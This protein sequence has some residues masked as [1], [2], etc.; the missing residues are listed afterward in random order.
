[1]KKRMMIFVIVASVLAMLATTSVT[2]AKKHTI[3][4]ITGHAYYLIEDWGD[5]EI[6]NRVVVKENPITGKPYIILVPK[7]KW[8]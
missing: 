3:N 2:L 5:T 4:K 6:W 8:K 1:M 7:E